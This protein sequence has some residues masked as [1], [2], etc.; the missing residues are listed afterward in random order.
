[1]RTAIL[2]SIGAGLM[3]ALPL[4]VA[5]TTVG[6]MMFIL[7]SPLPLFLAGLALGTQGAVIAGATA[8]VTLGLQGG[9]LAAIAMAVIMAGPIALLVRQALLNREDVAPDGTTRREWYPPGLLLASLA[10]IGVVWLV[11]GAGLKMGDDGGI[12]ASLHRDVS[13]SLELLVPQATPEERKQAADI[14]TPLALGVGLLSWLLLLALN[15]ILAQGLLVRFSRNL[16]PSPRLS[17]IEVPN[18]LAPVIAATLAVALLSDGNFGYVAQNL[19]LLL[20]LPYFFLGL[21]VVHA[22]TQGMQ[23]R[24]VV[25]TIFY[26]A[27]IVLSIW[28]SMIVVALGLI[29]QW[30][31]IRR[32]VSQANPDS[33]E[34]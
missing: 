13:Q 7:I 14:M 17:Q 6:G 20:V 31:G 24:T 29:E 19:A 1:M 11:A 3:S 22:L 9:A 16:R 8:T 27:L 23:A 18:W 33:E 10:M 15:G 2:L 5:L 32:R 21:S 26:I 34:D 4:V 25:L 12:E 28:P 30:A